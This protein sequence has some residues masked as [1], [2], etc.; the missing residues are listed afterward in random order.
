MSY[1]GKKLVK[2]KHKE[3]APKEEWPE[4]VGKNAEE[5]TTIIDKE[6]PGLKI[7][8]IP[9]NSFVV[10]NFEEKRVRLFVD[11]EQTVV[12]TPQLG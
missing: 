11:K 7:Q 2:W 1:L 6:Q 10:K 5:A 4:L 9:Q 8:I 3:K 12:K